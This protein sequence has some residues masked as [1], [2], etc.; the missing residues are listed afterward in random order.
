MKLI[1]II[2]IYLVICYALYLFNP[3]EM[4]GKNDIIN[5]PIICLLLSVALALMVD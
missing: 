4:I 3:E 1:P 2:I 5:Y